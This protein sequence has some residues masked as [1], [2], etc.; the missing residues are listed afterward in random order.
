ML[1]ARRVPSARPGAREA[2]C[3]RR[4]RNEQTASHSRDDEERRNEAE[5]E[6][7]EASIRLP[8]TSGTLT[9]LHAR[10]T[11][12]RA[13]STPVTHVVYTHAWPAMRLR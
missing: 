2:G 11:D 9:T 12:T 3:T 5:E 8:T 10:G 7:E 1:V 13:P 6:H 4:A